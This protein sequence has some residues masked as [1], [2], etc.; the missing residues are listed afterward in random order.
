MDVN[1]DIGIPALRVGFLKYG[2]SISPP[3]GI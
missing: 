3:W 1:I 2:K